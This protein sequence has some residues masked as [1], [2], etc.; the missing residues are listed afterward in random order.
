SAACASADPEAG[1]VAVAVEVEVA[2]A[3]AASGSGGWVGTLMTS[4]PPPVPREGIG[5]LSR[6]A[7]IGS[8]GPA[9]AGYDYRRTGPSLRRGRADPTR[10]TSGRGR[11][12]SGR[13]DPR[14]H[15]DAHRPPRRTGRR[16]R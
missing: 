2:A 1:S 4:I 9:A 13:G 11:S 15:A 16:L 3:V 8:R 14:R 5:A 7:S 6:R 12:R 10:V